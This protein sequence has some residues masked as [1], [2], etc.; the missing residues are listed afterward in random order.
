MR[1][2]QVLFYEDPTHLK[3]MQEKFPRYAENMVPWAEQT[4]GMHTYLGQS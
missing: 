3:P 1:V 4:N 2:L